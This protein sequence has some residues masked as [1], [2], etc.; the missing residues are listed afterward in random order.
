MLIGTR[1]KAYLAIGL[2]VIWPSVVWAEIATVADYDTVSQKQRSE[3]IAEMLGSIHQY[4]QSNEETKL[5]ATCME[6]LYNQKNASGT[7]RIFTVIVNEIDFA[8][9]I[10][11]RAYRVDEII[12]GV[13]ER[14]CSD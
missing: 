2:S 14:E 9:E 1:M 8:R 3:Y 7:P 11:P 4:Y 5:K 10:D 6:D 12:F 13:I